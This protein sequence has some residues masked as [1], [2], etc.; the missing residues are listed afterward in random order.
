MAFSPSS[1]ITGA[2]V[3][4]LTSPTYTHGADTSPPGTASKQYAVSALG[5]TQTGVDV[6]SVSKPFTFTMFKPTNFKLLGQPNN[7][8]VIR[9]FPRN[10]FELLT[11]KGIGVLAD[12]PNQ[13]LM[14]RTSFSIP[15]GSDI[16]EPEEIRAAVSL[17][18]GLLWVQASGIADL[19]LT[20]TL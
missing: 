11:R 20:G 2:T 15:A 3:S 8:G 4:G 14:I 10:S 19:I 18:C 17:H 6:H 9:N 13:I 12:Q 5:G 16:Y 7:A 1:P